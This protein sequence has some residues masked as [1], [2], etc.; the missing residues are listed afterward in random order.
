M[1]ERVSW[2]PDHGDGLTRTWTIPAG[3]TRRHWCKRDD[4]GR[5]GHLCICSCGLGRD[6]RRY[7]PVSGT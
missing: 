4:H 5:P 3:A 1:T 7:D 2:V 6:G